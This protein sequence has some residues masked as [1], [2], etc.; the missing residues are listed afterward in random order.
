VSSNRHAGVIFHAQIKKREITSE[1]AFE[2]NRFLF[3]IFWKDPSK[4]H[5]RDNFCLVGADDAFV[6]KERICIMSSSIKM[7][8]EYAAEYDEYTES[9]WGGPD[10][11][12]G[13]SRGFMQSQDNLVD[14]GIGTGLGAVPFTKAGL[15]VYGIDGSKKMLKICE[16][17]GIAKDLKL[18]NLE[19][20]PLPYADASFNH[21]IS[22]GL[23]HFVSNLEPLFKDV[24]RIIKPGGIFAFTYMISSEKEIPENNDEDCSTVESE[25]VTMYMYRGETIDKYLHKSGFKNLKMMRYLVQNGP[26]GDDLTFAAYASQKH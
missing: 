6:V 1:N 24:S 12:F 3:F 26:D 21:A 19:E 20:T 18:F 23:F 8:D 2:R 25:G 13:M 14:I 5:F 9:Q 22:L 10:I 15:E 4:K 16:E 7:H 17:K 11:V